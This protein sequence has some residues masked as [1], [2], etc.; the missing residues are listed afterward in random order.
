[1]GAVRVTCVHG[2]IDYGYFPAATLHGFT[3][4]RSS[5]G[6]W[7]LRGRAVSWDA[8]NLTRTPLV[9]VVPHMEQKSKKVGEWRWPVRTVR[10]EH[11]DVAAVLGP[12]L[13]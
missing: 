7:S 10:V 1:M 12:L 4:T 9:L 3:V 2:R 6:D 5:K 11:G 8:F 13:E